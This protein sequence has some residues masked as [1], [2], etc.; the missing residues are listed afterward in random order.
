[1]FSIHREQPS[2]WRVEVSSGQGSR[3]VKTS[4]HLTDKPLVDHFSFIS[5]KVPRKA[6]SIT[7]LFFICIKHTL[8][9]TVAFW[10]L[11]ETNLSTAPCF[12]CATGRLSE[13]RDWEDRILQSDGV[14]QPSQLQLA[15]QN[16]QLCS[17]HCKYYLINFK[18]VWLLMIWNQK[19]C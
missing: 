1:M 16:Q 11:K 9:V 5:G 17:V 7:C 10:C 18:H 3:E 12:R 19:V 4:L 15:G 13:R 6:A 2:S 14:L 8:H